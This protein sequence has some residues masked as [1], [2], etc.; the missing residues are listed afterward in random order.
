MKIP[1]EP[2]KVQ[3]KNLHMYLD[4]CVWTVFAIFYLC[5]TMAA[6]FVLHLSRDITKLSRRSLCH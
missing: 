2:N 3:F 4:S 5:L 6:V 1:P